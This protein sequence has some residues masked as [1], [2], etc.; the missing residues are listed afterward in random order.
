MDPTDKRD[1]HER[2]VG[3]TS[4]T[5]QRNAALLGG[6]DY[7]KYPAAITGYSGQD[8]QRIFR[9]SFFEAIRTRV[10]PR[11]NY[12][13]GFARLADGKLL[14]AVCRKSSVE[15]NSPFLIDVYCSLDDGLSWEAVA[16]TD[17]VGKE[18]SLTAL[19]DGSVL[20]TAQYADFASDPGQQGMYVARSRDAGKTW[21]AG[22]I[23]GRRYPRN[24]VVE[25]DG[26]LLFLRPNPGLNLELC[27]SVDNGQSWS[28]SEGILDW[29]PEDKHTFDEV[30]TLRLDDGTLIAALRHEKPGC[31]GEGFE[32]TLITR[33]TDDGRSWAVPRPMVN[34]AEVHVYLTKLGSGSI[35]ATYSNYHLPY[36]VC[37]IQS[38]DGGH[39]WSSEQPLQL[40]LSA[41]LYVG[42]P[43]TLELPGGDLLTS[44]ASTS[45]VKEPPD[46][47]TCEVVRWRLPSPR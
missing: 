29:R 6:Y 5:Q 24:I 22:Q 28:F 7:S 27:R 23:E 14:I 45:Y 32:D 18:P 46:T 10:G 47:T 31:H 41:D 11:G 4:Q 30:S 21:H 44:Y 13:A 35:L 9:T 37:A 15:Q 25:A 34:T 38:A 1:Q 20:M 16:N 12:K 2:Q 26:S 8:L 39:T 42:W 17:I 3:L 40:A 43:V 33:S 19:A 36:G